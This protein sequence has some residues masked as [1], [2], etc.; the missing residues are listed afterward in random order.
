MSLA[1]SRG[2]G[3]KTGERRAL[4]QSGGDIPLDRS[5]EL[6]KDP[7]HT[8]QAMWDMIQSM[9]RLV[10][11]QLERQRA[12]EESRAAEEACR[13]LLGQARQGL[14]LLTLE[15]RW[16]KVNSAFCQLLGLSDD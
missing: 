14:A 3:E 6:Q 5:E 13:Q 15:G 1:L 4:N 8:T 9:G 16:G 11:A 10:Q 2:G 7:L 12:A